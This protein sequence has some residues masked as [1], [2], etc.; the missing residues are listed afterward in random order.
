MLPQKPKISEGFDV[1]AYHVKPNVILNGTQ[2]PSEVLRISRKAGTAPTQAL[3]QQIKRMDKLSKVASRGG[4]ALS[5]VGLGV[6]CHQIAHTDSQRKKNEILVESAGGVVGGIVYGIGAGLAVAR[7]A[8]PVGWVGAL[9]IGVGGAAAGFASGKVAGKLYNV[10]GG[11]I[12]IASKTGIS[13]V[14]RATRER[15]GT[16]RLLSNNAMSVL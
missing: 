9:V 11:Q 13:N 15:T 6:A 10:Y 5:V 7:M 16:T 12:D 14:C 1:I 2:K 3:S 4:V 8:T